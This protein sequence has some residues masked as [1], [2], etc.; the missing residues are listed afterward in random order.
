MSLVMVAGLH[1][2]RRAF[3]NIKANRY[4]HTHNIEPERER[5]TEREL[6]LMKNEIK[7][8]RSWYES[9]HVRLLYAHGLCGH[10][11]TTDRYRLPRYSD[12]AADDD[13]AKLALGLYVVR[14]CVRTLTYTVHKVQPC[15]RLGQTLLPMFSMWNSSCVFVFF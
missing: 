9:H 1:K 10:R 6:K 11:A 7:V 14:S 3:A 4:G 15:L 13:H 8:V 12:A 2:Y 5:G